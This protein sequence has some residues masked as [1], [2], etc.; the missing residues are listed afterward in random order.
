MRMLFRRFRHRPIHLTQETF[1]IAKNLLE[2]GN[3]TST[4]EWVPS[5]CT[6]SVS[7]N[8]I[9]LI[10]TG[11]SPVHMLENNIPNS[12]ISGHIYYVK[13][14][15]L[16]EQSC[17]YLYMLDGDNEARR[18]SPNI[19]TWYEL[20][21]RGTR[22]YGVLEIG[23][24]AATAQTVKVKKVMA[25][26]LTAI[27]GAGNEPS[28]PDVEELLGAFDDYF[29]YANVTDLQATVDLT[30]ERQTSY[31]TLTT[32]ESCEITLDGITYSFGV[33]SGAQTLMP[34]KE[35][36]NELACAGNG[37]ITFAWQEGAL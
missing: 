28:S 31:P 8:I 20:A 34:L 5:N 33:I 18:T 4:D 36:L 12:A 16:T 32:E 10:P 26:D 19:N 9:T 35:G 3:F 15:I 21:F 23:A 2:N 27:Y 6:L 11:A 17:S 14:F 24:S 37:E 22:G 13:C 29:E 1:V 7:D 30:N 25:L